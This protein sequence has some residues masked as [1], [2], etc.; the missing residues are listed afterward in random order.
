VSSQIRVAVR[1]LGAILLIG[2]SLFC[3]FGFLASY[4]FGFPNVWH[5]LYCAVGV[6]A[7]VTAM[8]L[9]F[10]AL[11]RVVAG[12]ADRDWTNYRRLYRLAA[13]LTP[14]EKEETVPSH[15]PTTSTRLRGS[16]RHFVRPPRGPAVPI[17]RRK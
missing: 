5:F 6:A 4:E 3:G 10:P 1:I 13:L 2:L 16:R 12:A 17:A 9:V 15:R 11:R 8:W 7:V 14:G